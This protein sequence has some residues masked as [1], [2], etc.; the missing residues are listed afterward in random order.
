MSG[1]P[2]K[3]PLGRTFIIAVFLCVGTVSPWA[4]QRPVVDDA[5]RPIRTSIRNADAVAVVIG[6]QDY[7]HRDVP[8][9]EF[10]IND[11][12]AVRRVLVQTLG[13]L[14]SRVLLR[15][16]NQASIGRMKPLFRQELRSRVIPG[17]SDV[18]VYFSGHG[19]PN[20]DT[21]EGYLIPWDYD[22]QYAPSSDSAYSLRELYSDLSGLPARSVTVMLEA[23]FSGQSDSGELTKDASPLMIVIDNPLGLLSNS[24]I[25]TA[26]GAN[27]IATWYR[28]SRH[29]LTTYFWLRAMRGE[30]GD[31]E[32]RITSN[33]LQQYLRER[34]PP[35]AQQLR[36]RNQTPTVIAAQPDTV[37]A[38]LPMSAV[39]T[40]A[41]RIVETYGS[42]RVS[43]DVGGDLYIDGIRQDT[44]PVGRAFE[45]EK[46][47]AGPHVIEVRRDGYD[48]IREE[49]IVAADQQTRKTYRLT[50]NLPT[51][52]RPVPSRIPASPNAP[53]GAVSGPV[54]I[55]LGALSRSETVG[56][57]TRDAALGMEF[58][59]IPPGEFMMGCSG[60]DNECNDDEKPA[61]RVRITKGFE[62]GIYEVT[63]AQWEAVMR[64][65]PSSF[66]G[67]DRPVEQVSWNDV[68][69]FLQ[70][71]NARQDGYRYRLPTEAEWEYAARAST[72]GAYGA[73]TDSL[74]QI[75]WYRQN[76]GNE[77]H[78]VRQKRSNE[79]GI[80]DTNGNVAEWVQ[81]RYDRNYYRSSLAADPVGPSN[82][83]HRVLRGGSWADN[84]WR[85]RVSFRSGDD[86][87]LRR[88]D[89]G[90]RCVREAVQ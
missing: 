84:A 3:L 86:S 29:G 21:K 57:V 88:N 41:A 53:A 48:T 26:S 75:G 25:I 77:T 59:K 83:Q 68:Q 36:G 79:W 27:E 19:A 72:P 38:R 32:G 61:H 50:V 64:S 43:I 9:V 62:I 54:L 14:E 15:T 13:Y 52:P 76:S 40:G 4:Q 20:A 69:Q 17:R 28:E 7:D 74:E 23:C 42:L 58:V 63:Q 55:E 46:I 66:K 80:Y 1:S 73:Y 81:D 78:I 47:A 10:A 65:N 85:V 5:D 35:V 16:N 30:A 12:E 90:F 2:L 6:V 22:P 70:K 8:D 37:L 44:I 33:Q 31:A 24:V 89:L 49:V 39:R 67:A 51:T 71:V 11:A 87:D 56:I 60:G 82:G 18:F 45:Q 34:V